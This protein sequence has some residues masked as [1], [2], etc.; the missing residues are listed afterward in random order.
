[1]VVPLV[2]EKS[3]DCHQTVFDLATKKVVAV[4]AAIVE[5]LRSVVSVSLKKRR[6]LSHSPVVETEH[7][8]PSGRHVAGPI[9]AMAD[10]Q[11]GA[12]KPRDLISRARE[13]GA[14]TSCGTV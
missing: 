5:L 13:R 10:M 2:M 4:V 7:F 8:N 6:A 12:L 1:M 3:S 14:S 11:Y 9:A